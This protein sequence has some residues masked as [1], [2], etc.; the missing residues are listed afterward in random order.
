MLDDCRVVLNVLNGRGALSR[1]HWWV[2]DG[3][4][5]I[6]GIN[7]INVIDGSFVYR[8]YESTFVAGRKNK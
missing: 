7:G 4:C 5:L 2:Y 3:I 1:G 6:F 8:L